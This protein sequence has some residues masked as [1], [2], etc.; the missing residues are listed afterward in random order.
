MGKAS[1]AIKDMAKAKTLKFLREKQGYS[2]RKL[3]D[4]LFISK[5]RAHQMESGSEN[6][7]NEYIEKFLKVIELDWKSWKMELSKQ[8]GEKD[9][10][11]N[12]CHEI[13][14]I[15]DPSKI[16]IIHG[17]LRNFL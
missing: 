12:E 17:V 7:S 15:I 9:E 3:A 4:L 5:T 13:L 2:L 10:L 14:D 6:I 11:L 8:T 16:E 1:S